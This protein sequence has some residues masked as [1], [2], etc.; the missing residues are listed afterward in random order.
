MLVK[1]ATRQLARIVTI[2]AIKPIPKA[3]RLKN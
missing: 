3:D 1:D 2:D